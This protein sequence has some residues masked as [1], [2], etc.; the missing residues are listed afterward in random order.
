[1][2]IKKCIISNDGSKMHGIK[3]F[4]SSE[5]KVKMLIVLNSTAGKFITYRFLDFSF[6]F[7]CIELCFNVVFS[8]IIVP[9]IKFVF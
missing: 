3:C 7:F 5:E 4:V 9:T 1:M 8:N 6:Y 2:W